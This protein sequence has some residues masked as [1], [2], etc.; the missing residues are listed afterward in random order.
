MNEKAKIFAVER[1]RQTRA[2][3]KQLHTRIRLINL[4]RIRGVEVAYNERNSIAASVCVDVTSYL[5]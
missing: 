2:S 4:R 1:M 3:E 5:M